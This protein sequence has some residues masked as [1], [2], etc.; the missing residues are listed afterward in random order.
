M[1]EVLRPSL[2]PPERSYDGGDVSR[3][4]NDERRRPFLR[5][6]PCMELK[7]KMKKRLLCIADFC[8]RR[9]PGATA[10]ST[11]AIL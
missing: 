9:R 2:R 11:L 4:A 6:I 8:R 7:R 1:G 10:F 5:I 3:G